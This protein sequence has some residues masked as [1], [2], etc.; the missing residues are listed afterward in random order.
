MKSKVHLFVFDAEEGQ[1]AFTPFLVIIFSEIAKSFERQRLK[2]RI[3]CSII[4]GILQRYLGNISSKEDV[5]LASLIR[6][7]NDMKRQ[8]SFR[9]SI[10]IMILGLLFFILYLYFFVGFGDILEILSK[11]DPLEYFMY[12]SL[13]IIAIMVSIIFYA[14]T[15]HDILKTLSLKLSLKRAIL[16]SWV[17]NF[18][19]LV[20]PLET[21]S[22]ELTRLYLIQRDIKG[23]LGRIVASLVYHRIISISTTLFSLAASSIYLIIAY[24]IRLD[25]I[26]FL[27]SVLACTTTTIILILYLSLNRKA[28]ER[29]ANVIIKVASFLIKDQK[30]LES[31]K[32]RIMRELSVFYDAAVVLGK[33]PWMLAKPLLYS[34][35]SW[36]SQLTVYLLVFYALGVSWI[37]YY[38]PQLIIVFSITLAVQTIP[39]GFPVGLVELVMTYLYNILLKTS[40]AMNGLATSL[41]RIVTFW[42]QI[43][44][45]LIIVQWMGLRHALESEAFMNRKG[46]LE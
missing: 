37:I 17:G 33:N 7:E 12:Y 23:D 16:Y 14:M 21:I 19:D 9:A 36:F 46:I 25:I 34:Y 18:V 6:F 45:G 30:R 26:I 44:V 1:G 4:Q 11:I 3:D 24:K 32:G 41:I 35:L 28:A 38:I 40:P 8:L 29:I 13:S 39:V 27:L 31:L 2:N 5:D 15:W 42:F 43:I 22:G 10:I 20:L